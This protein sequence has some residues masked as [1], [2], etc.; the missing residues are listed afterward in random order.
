MSTGIG[1]KSKNGTAASFFRAVECFCFYSICKSYIH[2]YN[3]QHVGTKSFNMHTFI[4]LSLIDTQLDYLH[5][6]LF[7]IKYCWGACMHS[8]QQQKR[9]RWSNQ[10]PASQSRCLTY[11]S[12]HLAVTQQDTTLC[13]LLKSSVIPANAERL[14]GSCWKSATSLVSLLIN[15][16]SQVRVGNLSTVPLQ[17]LSK[18]SI[19]LCS[20]NVLTVE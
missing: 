2:H 1:Y 15:I 8:Q 10:A 6:H 9:E 11:V 4:F 14:L 12:T 18:S 19:F 17:R 13:L 5:L 3:K 20:Q 16:K 7:L